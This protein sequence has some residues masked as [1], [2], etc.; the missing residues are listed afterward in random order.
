MNFNTSLRRLAM[1]FI[2]A[3]LFTSSNAM[4]NG[5][6]MV[7]INNMNSGQLV[8][9]GPVQISGVAA[10]PHGIKRLFGTIQDKRT[11][12]FFTADGK[13]VK[14]PTR[15]PFRF[16]ATATSTKWTT[17]AM[18]LPSGEYFYRMRAEDGKETRSDI[19]EVTLLVRAASQTSTTTLAKPAKPTTQAAVQAATQPANQPAAKP[20]GTMATNGMAY[21]SNA[22]MDADGDGYGWENEKSCVV[23]GSKADTHPNCASAA[24]D[25]DGDGYGWENERSCIVVVRCQSAGSDPDGDGW[26]WENNKSCVVVKTSGKHPQCASAKSDPDGD[27][28]GW[29]NNATCLVAK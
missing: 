19:L 12:L 28:Y 26:G 9:K 8:F 1:P 2:A 7:N 6:P 15:L 5:A 10:D 24:S 3:A 4:A 27:G 29:E 22:G 11:Q 21:C 18:A 16:V 14:K 13:F 20:A 17:P 25:P 23:A